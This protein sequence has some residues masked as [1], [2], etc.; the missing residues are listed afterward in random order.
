MQR[1]NPPSVFNSV[2]Y[3]FSQAVSVTG[4]RTIHLSGQVGMDANEVIV[5]GFKEQVWLA[6]KNMQAVL[7]NA[8]ATLDDV[9]SMRI[10]VVSSVEDS[11]P[12]S[13]MLRTFFPNPPATTWL[14]IAGLA[15]EGLLVELEAVA[16]IGAA[17]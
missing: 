8:G 9:V 7:E 13:E 17:T 14:R 4:G 1:H 11:A 12:V 5:E 2:Q 10:Y 3:G 15:R 6:V 16:V